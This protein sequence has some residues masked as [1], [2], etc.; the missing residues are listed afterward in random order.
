[1][2]SVLRFLR[3][4]P[5]LVFAPLLLILAAVALALTDLFST[6]FQRKRLPLNT[7]PQCVAASIVIPTWNAKDLIEK[8]LPNVIQAVS[9]NP[10]NEV[11]VVDNGSLDGTS[12]WLRRTFPQVKVL[13]LAQNLG[14]GRG[15]NVGVQAAH[16]DIV[17]LLNNDMKV[18]PGFLKPLLEGFTDDMVFSVSSQI[19]FSDPQK[20]REETG[21]TE[22]WWEA[23]SLRVR[24]RVDESITDLYP[25]FYGGGGATAYDKKK[26][27]ELGGFDPLL[28]PFYLEDTDLGYLAWK[29]GWKVLYQPRSVVYHEHRGTIGRRFTPAEIHHILA[30][31]F[32]LWSWKNIHDWKKLAVHFLLTYTGAIVSA[33]AGD[34]PERPSVRGIY[35]AF[36]YMPKA[37]RSRWKARRLSIVSDDEGFRRPLGGYFRD[38][39]VPMPANPSQ[40]K[41][42]FVS[43]YPIVPPTHGGGV[44]MHETLSQLAKLCNLHLIVR[45]DH[46]SELPA[47]ELLRPMVASCEF[48]VRPNNKHASP[49]SLL[50][51]AVREFASDD[52]AWLIHRQIYT[53]QIDVV[54]LEYLPMAQY[55]GRY[56][57]IA[58]V[59]FEHDIYFQSLARGLTAMTGVLG[60][61]KAAVEYLRALHYE[62]RVLP[63]LDG[64]QVC[65]R[66]NRQYLLSFVPAL[67]EKVWD[68]LRV[69]VQTSRYT[70]LSHGREPDTMLFV[71]SFR[72]L[73]NQVA[74]KWFTQN[75]LPLVVR[76]RP[77]SRLIVVGSDPPPAHAFTSLDHIELR[78]FVEDV[79]EPMARYAVFVC[80]IL[81]GSGVRVKLIEAFASGIPVVSTRLGAEGLASDDGE[82]CE[83]ADDPAAFARKILALFEDPFRAAEMAAR[84]RRKVVQD[85]DIFMVTRRLEANYRDIVRRKRAT[86]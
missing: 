82:F 73:P 35:R 4:V 23:G 51:H 80:P 69:G 42:L 65:S 64:I 72:H 78:G 86:L 29:R 19:F 9:E 17:V 52:L 57:R 13:Q 45:L 39:F 67:S 12:D 41:V 27:L 53:K 76:A 74:L 71:G 3:L 7:R 50:P 81:T 18:D 70:F 58:T 77:N 48:M 68:G 44:L 56:R 83:L 5:L 55:A 54:Q 59:V 26:F 43:P 24:H 10:Q 34:S 22:G 1:M 15:S 6:I 46:P 30:R 49:G 20:R 63:Q 38:R 62:T 25:C 31:N 28:S 33:L 14:F 85:W 66:E 47:H 84:A 79:R 75:V 16:N 8:Y 36:C 61:A 2:K 32:I 11:I 40:L 37:L 21:L 60:K